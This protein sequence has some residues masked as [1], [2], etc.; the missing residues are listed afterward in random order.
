MAGRSKLLA[1]MTMRCPACGEGRLFKHNS[2]YHPK[3]V[4][5]MYDECPI[6]QQDFKIEPG[7]YFGAAYISYGINVALF[8][9][10]FFIVYLGFGKGMNVF[11][12]VIL[13]I[14]LVFLPIIFR[15]SRSIW[16][17]IFVKKDR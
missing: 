2:L 12:P 4:G 15:L 17:H 13:G 9:S 5:E 11:I 14:L 10:T 8:I 16:L 1:M 7:F 6:C 3:K